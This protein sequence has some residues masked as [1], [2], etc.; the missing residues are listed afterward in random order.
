[1][2]N[3]AAADYTGLLLKEDLSASQV[4]AARR[5]AFASRESRAA[6]K[7]FAAGLEDSHSSASEKIALAVC[8][9][10]HGRYDKAIET[11]RAEKSSEAAQFVLG[12]SLL[13]LGRCAEAK[14]VLKPLA[15]KTKSA[16][17]Y[18]ALAE[19]LRKSGDVAAAAS[20][21]KEGIGKAG[22]GAAL[23]CEAGILA[24]IAGD[25]AAA[26]EHYR[27]AVDCDAQHVEALFRIAY[28]ADLHGDEETALELYHRCVQIR[29]VRS[30]ALVNLGLL[31]E[32]LG[33]DADAAACFRLVID[34]HPVDQRAKLYLR[35]AE[36]SKDMFFDEEQQKRR[37]R[38]NKILETPITDFEL[39][40]RSRNCLEKMNVTTV[41]DLCRITETDLLG[42]KNFGET[43]LNEIKAMMT[44]KGL[45]L[46][47]SLEGE[48]VKAPAKVK[49]VRKKP[50]DQ[51]RLLLK[52]VDELGLSVRSQHCMQMLGIKTIGDLV[53]LSEKQLM[54]ARN[55]GST[56]LTEVKKKL[57][58]SGLSLAP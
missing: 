26:Q 36:A 52:P 11:A 56:S 6:F 27:K 18:A 50:V 38:R 40:V 9:W 29:P 42:F 14:D 15:T 58:V 12:R 48:D 25:S 57:A 37:D 1:M 7:E 41:G 21:V 16:D 31:Y 4:S 39:S 33:R 20:A 54:E 23:H 3:V 43:S 45:R 28:V 35:D 24:D 53:A 44:S 30:R 2:T 10:I 5:M 51:S 49:A 47:Q 22:A 55:F 46:G 8:R 13:A 19:T 34:N 17:A 32:E